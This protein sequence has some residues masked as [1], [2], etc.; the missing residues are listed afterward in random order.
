MMHTPSR[1]R[2]LLRRT[3]TTPATRRVFCF[4]YAGA[5]A[6]SFLRWSEY[7]PKATEVIGIQLPGREN[8][9]N[10]SCADS[11]SPVIEQLVGELRP[12]LDVPYAFFGHSFGALLSVEVTHALARAGLPLPQ[13]ITV[14][15]A[16]PPHRRL[17]LN[18]DAMSDETLLH[19][20]GEWGGS[21]LKTLGKEFVE[22]ALSLLRADIK[23][24][25]SHD[26][27]LH[28]IPAPLLVLGGSADVLVSID[29]LH[30][31]RGLAASCEVMVLPGNHFFFE[32]HLPTT[33]SGVMQD[34]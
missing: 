26:Y 2:W 34:W 30:A 32:Q 22:M 28:K 5:G 23:L 27:A 25:Q 15:G 14:S 4:P 18:L 16:N 24:L 19:V 20:I 17:D 29:A 33:I 1:S 21:R 11:L 8:R 3:R 12:L 7:L 9:I 10:E 13:K 31:W 6:S